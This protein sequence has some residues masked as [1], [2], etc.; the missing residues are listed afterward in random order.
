MRYGDNIYED[1]LGYSFNPNEID[2]S[3]ENISLYY[4]LERLHNN[5]IDLFA[6]YQRNWNLWSRIQQSR[7]IES[8]LIRIPIPSFYFDTRSDGRWQIVDGLQRV[9]TFYNFIIQGNFRLVGLEFLPQFNGYT[10]TE[11]PR[12]LQ[13]RIEEFSLSI[14][15]INRETPEEIKF[16]IFSRINTGGINL[17]NQELRYA[18]N[19][20]SATKLLS[21]LS[22]SKE[23]KEATFFSVNPKRMNDLEFIN[24][25]FSF[26]L[27]KHDYVGNL[28]IFLNQ[29]LVRINKND[30]S[31]DH[32]KL[33]FFKSME[34]SIKIF[35]D[36][37]FIKFDSINLVGRKRINKSLFDAVSVNLAWLSNFELEILFQRR[38]DVIN[39]LLELFQDVEFNDSISFSTNSRRKVNYRFESIRHLFKQII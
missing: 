24:R 2:I 39:G 21:E 13:R 31:L 27:F 33:E 10:F 28:E 25:F 34:Y 1:D 19:Q 14:Y 16:I 7:L 38:S 29:T 26:Y 30:F 12:E 22:N 35:E 32:L 23:F 3:V 36:Y 6:D 20:G 18:L 11:L 4:L 37:R 5:E 15:L 17:N 8:I 9:T